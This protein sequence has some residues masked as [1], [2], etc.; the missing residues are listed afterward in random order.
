VSAAIELLAAD[1]GDRDAMAWRAALRGWSEEDG[2]EPV[3]A[4]DLRHSLAHNAFDLKLTLPEVSR[5][6][7]H[8]NARVTARVYAGIAGNAVAMLQERLSC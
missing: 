5:L 2:R 1:I 4:P 7:R 6:L 8:A 3:G